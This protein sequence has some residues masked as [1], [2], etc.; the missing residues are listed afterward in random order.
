MKICM[1]I[2]L[3][4]STI[5][6]IM[7]RICSAVLAAWISENEYAPPSNDD[8]IRLIKWVVRKRFESFKRH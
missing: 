3:I 8:Y 6:W 5:N 7:W 1:F 4:I 2:A